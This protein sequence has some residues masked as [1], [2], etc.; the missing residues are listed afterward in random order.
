M[1]GKPLSLS[2]SLRGRGTGREK[3]PSIAQR[4]A[5]FVEET[6]SAGG[7]C[8][9]EVTDCGLSRREESLLDRETLQWSVL[10]NWRHTLLCVCVGAGVTQT[11]G[12][13]EGKEEGRGQGGLIRKI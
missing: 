12:K 3:R 9:M 7:R 4:T 5:L 11:A 1:D 10:I 2:L 6:R 8:V 13:G